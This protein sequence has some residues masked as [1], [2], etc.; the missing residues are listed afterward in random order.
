MTVQGLSFYMYVV[1][2]TEKRE[3]EDK[4]NYFFNCTMY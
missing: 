4:G 1:L 3:R 2:E